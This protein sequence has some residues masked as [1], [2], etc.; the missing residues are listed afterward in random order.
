MRPYLTCSLDDRLHAR[1][2]TATAKIKASSV[3]K[4]NLAQ[5]RNLVVKGS[6]VREE[7]GIDIHS[8]SEESKGEM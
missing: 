3:T 1:S 4:R 2:L 6:E 8:N 5:H 7:G